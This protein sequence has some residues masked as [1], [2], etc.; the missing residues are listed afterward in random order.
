MY[1]RKRSEDNESQ[2]VEQAPHSRPR[3][4][5]H[6]FDPVPGVQALSEENA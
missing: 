2:K 4:G 6:G 1:L 3:S 5:Y